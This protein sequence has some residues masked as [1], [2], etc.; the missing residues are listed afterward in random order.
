MP[1]ETDV[2]IIGAGGAGLSSA[3]ALPRP[4]QTY[5]VYVE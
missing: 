3:K 4:G 2:I 5:I 1:S